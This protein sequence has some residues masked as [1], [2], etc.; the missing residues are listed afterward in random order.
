M[1][2]NIAN[3]IAINKFAFS[4]NFC[5]IFITI[6]GLVIFLCPTGIYVFMTFFIGFVIPQFITPTF[7]YNV[8]SSN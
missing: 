3:Y 1:H 4:I 5:V 7:F 2:R 8:N 6:E